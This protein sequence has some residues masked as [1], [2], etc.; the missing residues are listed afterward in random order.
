MELK[1]YLAERGKLVGDYLHQRLGQGSISPVDEAMEYSVEAGGKRLLP[2]LMMA[3][4]DA[5]G[6]DGTKFLPVASALEIRQH[7]WEVVSSKLEALSP[8]AV[9]QRG[10]SLTETD[11]GQ[12]IRSIS[13]VEPGSRLVTHVA[14]GTVVSTA[15]E[16]Q[17]KKEGQ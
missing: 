7:R 5:A 12:V 9:L 4:A 10:Y 1:S 15:Q 11:K 2:I 16:I 6:A 14:D 17:E 3:A 13:Q 8:Y